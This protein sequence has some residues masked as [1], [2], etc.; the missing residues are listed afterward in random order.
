MRLLTRLVAVAG[1][2]V[3]GGLALP[4]GAAQA[5][6]CSG[7]S[8]V[9]VVID[10]GSSSST[11]C[12][13]DATE[14]GAVLDSVAEVA[15]V[16]MYGEGKVVCKINNVPSSQT[17]QR[18]P[19]GS[20]YWA[21]FHASRGGSWIYSSTGVADYNPAPGTVI[22]FAF[23]S[24]GAPSSPPPAPS[25]STPKPSPKPSPSS[26][27]SSRPPA[28]TPKPAGTTPARPSSSGTSGSTP[29]P[30]SGASTRP[31]SP[32]SAT[33]GAKPST[34]TAPGTT[35][36]TTSPGTT[37]GST[38]RGESDSAASATPDSGSPL[39]LIA[40]LGLVGLVGA[41]AAYLAVRRRAST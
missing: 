28:P 24:G 40:G 39:T 31:G 27:S 35:T 25:S 37:S 33:P 26:S 10:Y 19:P 2:V 7:T 16:P 23:G 17:C 30:G 34:T 38:G 3:A 22:G 14:A 6:A 9:T 41:G 5:A 1:L 20:A 11:L 4:G 13:A 15:W 36:S 8:G 21:F 18:M 32:G 12:A 29:A